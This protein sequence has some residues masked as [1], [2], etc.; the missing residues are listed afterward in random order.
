MNCISPWRRFATSPDVTPDVGCRL[1]RVAR[2]DVH[3][4]RISMPWANAL[5]PSFAEIPFTS[6]S[7]L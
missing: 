5:K 2:D 7:Y 3:A 6:T 4:D 1:G